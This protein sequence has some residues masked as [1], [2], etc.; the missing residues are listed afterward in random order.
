M[1]GRNEAQEADGQQESAAKQN[2]NSQRDSSYTLQDA[3]APKVI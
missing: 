1:A 3:P 2:P